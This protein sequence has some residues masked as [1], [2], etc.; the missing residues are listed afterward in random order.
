M[1]IK[2]FTLALG[3]A[4]LFS[5]ATSV[6]ATQDCQSNIPAST[7]AQRFNDQGNGT[8]IDTYT[9][10]M[11]KKCLEGQN[12]E[13]CVG[14]ALR[15]EWDSAANLAQLVGSD[16]FAGYN[17][18]RLPTLDEL[19]SIVELRCVEP[20][21]NLEVFPQMPAVGLWSIN[22]ADPRAWSMDFD[23]GRAY[24]NF[25]GAGKYIRLVRNLR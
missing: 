21:A 10:L 13:R 25:K 3:S 24:E 12:G 22:Q 2:R 5:C 16:N 1:T 23:K 7:P 18:W 17:G 11:W 6:M 15:M 8:L 19:N 20:S 14:Q 9:G 4:L